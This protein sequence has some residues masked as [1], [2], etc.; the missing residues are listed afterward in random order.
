MAS[1]VWQ[2]AL[3]FLRT[4]N[5]PS[6]WQ[7]LIPWFTARRQDTLQTRFI[8]SATT[9]TIGDTPFCSEECRQEQ[10]DI[11][12][13]REKKLKM[14]SSMKSPSASKAQKYSI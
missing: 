11:D 4:Y 1:G 5:G 7:L 12:E 13:A 10:I 3:K 2:G 14:Y 6:H 9:S 8:A